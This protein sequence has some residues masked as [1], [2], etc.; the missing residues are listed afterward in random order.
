[1]YGRSGALRGSC[2][3]LSRADRGKTAAAAPGQACDADPATVPAQPGGELPPLFFRPRRGEILLDPGRVLRT[4][5]PQPKGDPRDVRVH[6]KSVRLK[7]GAEDDRRRLSSH[8][9]QR[10]KLFH[11]LRNGSPVPG[12]QGGGDPPERLGL[13]PVETRGSDRLLDLLLRGGRD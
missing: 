6:G 13:A 5:E 8:A 4:G 12:D 10:R 1:M 3:P 9:G 7:T 2:A 11:R